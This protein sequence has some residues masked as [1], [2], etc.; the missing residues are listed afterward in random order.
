[1]KFAELGL[2]ESLLEGIGY[3]GFEETTPIQTEAI[4]I[5]LENRDLLAC[6]QTGTGK[7]AAFVIP[8]LHLLAKRE[9]KGIAALI[10]APT[11][12]LA[13]QIDQQINALSYFVSVASIPIYGGGDGDS[14]DDQKKALTRGTD[15]IVATPGKLI[16]HIKMGY[17]DFSNLQFLILD[18]ADRML[19]M[20]FYED[21]MGIVK[22]LPKKRQNLLFSATMPN[23]IKK[24]AKE[25]LSDDHGEVKL[26]ISK[27]AEGILQAAYLAYD[28][29]KIPLL[30]R[31]IKDKPNYESILIF[32]STKKAVGDIVRA[33]KKN[34]IDVEGISSDLDQDDR[35][36]VLNKFRAR[37]IRVLVATDVMSR[38]IDI[39]EINL[40]INF[41]VPRNAEDYVH[42]VGRTARAETTGVAIT[43]VNPKDMR[44]FQ[45]IEELIE[46]EVPKMPPFP[47]LGEGPEWAPNKRYSGGKGKG[48]G[49][50]RK[51]R[52]SGRRK[53]HSRKRK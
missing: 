44:D 40:V 42:R 46:K 35:E 17:V 13:M 48:G 38:G 14:W 32:S 43:L 34:G 30:V 47:D 1:M 33:L 7:T 5:I 20:G 6:A 8:M 28:S 45:S 4:P 50:S 53:S 21:I 23:K 25:L 16:S 10:I 29:Q 12:E 11:R 24:L 9:H 2:D 37:N 52:S 27:P 22:K 19:D 51:G 26:A 49:R 15:V 31:L 36:K 3:M 39:K 18:E 41:D